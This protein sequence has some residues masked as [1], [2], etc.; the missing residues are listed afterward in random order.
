MQLEQISKE[1]S[2]NV[3]SLHFEPPVHYVYNPLDYA[4]VSH[5]NYLR[6]FAKGTKEVLLLGMNP[7]P[8]GMMQTGV[9]FGNV[10][11][12]RDWLN[13]KGTVQ[14][15]TKQHP[16]RPI[17]GFSCPRNEVS[18]QRLWG[19][20]AQRFT[21]AQYFFA[22]F[23][24]WNYC[25][26]GFVQES[27]RN[28]TPNKLPLTERQPLFAACDRAL[29]QVID[30]LQPKIIIGIG[31]FAADRAQN[32]LPQGAPRVAFA[33]HPSPANPQ[34]NRNWAAVFEQALTNAG[35]VLPT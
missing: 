10:A 25:P 15:P 32:A 11:S 16:K 18:G 33:P 35:V 23:M 5:V 1:L 19:W 13:I 34:A 31:R 6:R 28:H 26:L 20:A 2:D 4:W 24:V 30:A 14:S 22:R 9:P 27:G 7:G 29:I 17:Q 8:F 12:V 3:T 21:S